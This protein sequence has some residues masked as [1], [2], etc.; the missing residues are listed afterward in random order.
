MMAPRGSTDSR[1]PTPH[2]GSLATINLSLDDPDVE[3]VPVKRRRRGA[4]PTRRRSLF[5][6]L[7]LFAMGSGVVILGL[8]EISIACHL[9]WLDPRPLLARGASWMM[10]E[11]RPYLP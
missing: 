10:Q 6:K 8:C 7:L 5:V 9:P 1:R 4:R 2:R 3:V 11:L